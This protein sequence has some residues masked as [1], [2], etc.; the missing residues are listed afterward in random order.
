MID[1][2]Y[3]QCNTF[4]DKRMDHIYHIDDIPS[5]MANLMQE[6][7]QR[8]TSGMKPS[9]TDYICC[10]AISEDVLIMGRES[11][12]LQ[13]YSVPNITLTH[14]YKR[15]VRTHS[16]AINC[17]SRFVSRMMFNKYKFQ[18]DGSIF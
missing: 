10:L 8:Y 17:N 14:R 5:G 4:I 1:K 13:R 2:K 7:E 3:K 6:N 16:I 15:D 18:H 11:G 9:T 12:L